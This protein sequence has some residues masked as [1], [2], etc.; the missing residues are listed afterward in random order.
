VD[1][2][3]ASLDRINITWSIP[4]DNNAPIVQ[5]ILMFCAQIETGCVDGASTNVPLTVGIDEELISIEGNRLRYTFPQ[6][7]IGKEYEVVIRAENS[8]GQQMFPPVNVSSGFRF[9]SASPNDGQV[10]SVDFVRTTNVII[11]IWNLPTLA[12]ATTNLN[13]SFNVTYYNVGAPLN[14][15]SVTVD[16]DPMRLEQGVSVNI[17]E[18]DSPLHTFQITALYT[19]PNL[20]SSQATLG[21]VRTLANGTII[22]QHT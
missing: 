2:E 10:V 22:D 16:Y 11:L 19:H 1:A 20:L 21:G 5:Y 17:G 7:L 15:M 14:I 3:L 6:L 9:N 13:V 18:P 4:S 8:A 12:L